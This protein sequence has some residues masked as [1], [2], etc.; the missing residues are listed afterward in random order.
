MFSRNGKT[1]KFIVIFLVA[2]FSFFVVDFNNIISVNGGTSQV[3]VVSTASVS[4]DGFKH[5]IGIIRE[6]GLFVS[7][8]W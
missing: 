2:I 4:G 6:C 8:V 3:Y 7:E 5:I 1:Y